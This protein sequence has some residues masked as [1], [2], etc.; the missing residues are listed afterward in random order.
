MYIQW[1][2]GFVIKTKGPMLFAATWI[3]LE[4]IILSERQI[5]YAITYIWNLKY[6]TNEPIYRT[7]TDPWTRRKVLWLL[8]GRDGPGV[9][10][11]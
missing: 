1:E 6:G 3:D 11:W 5:L 10:G 8:R 2:Y 7:E 4:I 9:W